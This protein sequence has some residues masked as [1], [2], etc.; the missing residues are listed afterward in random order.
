[1]TG[2]HRLTA[3]QVEAAHLVVERDA[4]PWTPGTHARLGDLL[5]TT[6]LAPARYGASP[7]RRESEQVSGPGATDP[8]RRDV[9]SQTEGNHG[10]DAKRAHHD[11]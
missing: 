7:V 11:R 5:D 10:L 4:R 1:V 9:E 6:D 8:D 2:R 3:E